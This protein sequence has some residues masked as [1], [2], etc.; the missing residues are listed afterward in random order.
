[1]SLEIIF[2]EADA[3]FPAEGNILAWVSKSA[4]VP[5][6]SKSRACRHWGS[7]G[8]WEVLSSPPNDLRTGRAGDLFLMPS[9]GCIPP[10]KGAK[11]GVLR[12]YLRVKATKP[13][14]RGGRESEHF[15]V[16]RKQGNLP[17][18]TLWR[19][20]GAVLLEPLEGKMPGTLSPESV[21]TGLQRVATL[22]GCVMVCV[23]TQQ[24]HNMRS[25]MR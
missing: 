23:V 16:L 10:G 14:E 11:H 13:E 7:P 8:T 18:G 22:N 15:I 3:V 12:R 24:G 21:S 19:E 5:P 2:A 6:G 1:M 17:E 25:R 9:L 20:G 4:R